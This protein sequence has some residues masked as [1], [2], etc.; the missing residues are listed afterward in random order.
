MQ[1]DWAPVTW[2]KRAPSGAKAH[3]DKVV[4]E[5]MRKGQ[6]VEIERKIHNQGNK[7]GG[8]QNAAK[9]EEESEVFVTKRVGAEFKS[10]LQKARQAKG[11]TQSD[12]A[13]LINEKSTVINEYESGK[14][15]PKGDVIQKL[16]R[17]LGCVLPRATA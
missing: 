3:D 8:L 13:K 17:A 11:L 7:K 1:Q 4:N 15:I 6:G 14:A 5:A 2:S 9:I 16:N 12:L 10:A